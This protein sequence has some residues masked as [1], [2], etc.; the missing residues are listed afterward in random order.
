M[1]PDTIFSLASVL[2]M[3]G[4][5]ALL[6]SPLAPVWSDRIAGLA[7]PVFLSVGYSALLLVWG[8]GE[9]SYGDLA[10]VLQLF[11][12]PEGVLLGW[13]HFL[14]FDLWIGAWMCRTARA[15]GLRFWG[16]I[17]CLAVTFMFGPA[18]YLAFTV[19]RALQRRRVVPHGP[20]V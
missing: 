7:I 18:G 16:V 2:A 10:G 20:S 14:A 13:I 4:W 15:E 6:L 8:M 1:T 9:G 12:R 3:V 19:V 11:S 5:V 17:P